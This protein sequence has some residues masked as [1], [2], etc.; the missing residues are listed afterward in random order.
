MEMSAL[1]RQQPQQR[2]RRLQIRN[3]TKRYLAGEFRL[4]HQQLRREDE[5]RAL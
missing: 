5:L 4:A 1:L 2:R 3:E